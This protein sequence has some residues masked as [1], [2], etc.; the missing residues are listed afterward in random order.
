MTEK[1]AH[2]GR[3]GREWTERGVEVEVAAAGDRA[4]TTNVKCRKRVYLSG[5]RLADD[6]A[7]LLPHARIGRRRFHT[8]VL[9]RRSL[10]FVKLGE[11]RGSL[12]CLCRELDRGHSPHSPRHV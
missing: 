6:H 3:V 1:F 5:V 12:D 7:G 2:R 11:K 9:E 10:V 8:A 4:L